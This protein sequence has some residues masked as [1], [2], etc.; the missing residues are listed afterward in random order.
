MSED[1]EG[2]ESEIEIELNRISVSSFEADDSDTEVSDEASVCSETISDDLPE[3]VIS[4]LN[5][6]KS[7]NQ[8]AE[9]LIL[10]DL[11][12]GETT[13]NTY[14]IVSSH[15][16]DC[17]AEL[18]TE[19]NEDPE[20][21]KKR[22]LFEIENEDLQIATTPSYNSQS[23]SDE[24]VTDDCFV[25]ADLDMS[26][27]RPHHEAEEKCRQEF[28]QWEK[29]QKELEDKKRK[30][31]K[32]EREAQE[33]QNEE[34]HTRR[35]Q[36]PEEFE[37]ERVKLELLRK[38]HQT[39]IEDELEKEKKSWRDKMMQREELIMKLQ[40]Q[41]EEERKALEE[42]KAKERQHLAEQQNTAAV[43]IQARFRSFLIHKKYAPILKE[44]KDERKKKILE[45]IER[46][47]K[48]KEEKM[49]RQI[50]ENRQKKEEGKKRQEELERQEYLE[51]MRRHEE[52]E[53]KEESLRLERAKQLQIREEQRELGEKRAET[54]M[55]ESGENNKENIKRD[56]QTENTKIIREQKQELNKQVE[57]QKGKQTEMVDKTNNWIIPAERNLTPTPNILGSE[58]EHSSQVNNENIYMNLL[59]H[60]EEY[61]PQTRDLNKALNSYTSK[62]EFVNFG[63]SDMVKPKANGICS[64]PPN[65]QPS[66]ASNR[67]VK[68]KFSQSETMQKTVF[69]MEDANEEVR[70]TWHRIQDVAECS[71]R[72]IL[73]EDIEKKRINWMNTCKSWFQVYEEN[74][75]KQATM[76]KRPRKSSASKMPPLSTQKIIYSGP[77]STVHQVTTLT[78]EDLPAC[79]LSTLSEC[80][81]LQ[82]LTLRRCGLVA[83]EGL[84][85]CRDLKY[86]N[87]EENNIQMIDCEN[88]E[89]LCILILNKNHLSSVCGLDGCINL[90]NLEL[91]YNRIT[92]IG[93]LES[94]KNLQQLIVDHNQLISTKGLCEAPTLIHLDC[95]F[96]HL[97]QVEG[98]ENCGL[99][100]ILKL[101]SNNLQE[102]P[103]LENHVLLRELYLDDNNISTVRM[104]SFY[105]LPLLQILLL[106]QNRLTELMPLNSFVSLEKLDIKNNCLSDLKGVIAQLSG[107][108]KLRE[109]SVNG[110]PL[111]QE[112]NW[113]P[114][115]CKVLPSLQFLD[116]EILNCHTSPTTERIKGS[117]S[118]TFLGNCQVQIE[119]NVLLK[120]KAAELGIAS[121]IVSAQG[122]CWYFNQ[123]M[124]LSIKHRQAHEYGELNITDRGGPEA[125]QNHLKQTSTGCLQENNL[126]I[127][128]KTEDEQVLLDPSKRWIT[129]GHI[130]AT[131]INSFIPVHQKENKEDQ[132]VKQK[133][134][135]SCIN[136]NEESKDNN[137]MS[138]QLKLE[139]SV[140]VASN[141]ERDQQ[142]ENDTERLHA[143]ASVIQSRWRQ[144]HARRKADCTRTE[145]HQFIETL[146]QKHEAATLIQAFWKGFLLRKKLASALAAVKSD[147]VEDDYEEIN[148]DD[149]TFSEA[150]LEKEWLTVDSTRFPSKT[151]LL[152]NQL[153]WPKNSRPSSSC[154][155]ANT[156]PLLP[157]E[158]WQCVNRPHSY[159]A[160]N[161]HFHSRSGKGTMSQ[162]SDWKEKEKLSLISKKEEKISEEWGFKDISTAQLMLKRAHKMKP[163]KYSNKNLDPAVRLAL[164]KNNENKHLHVKPPRKTQPISAGYFEG[165]KE[166]FS[167]LDPTLY[168]K[169]QKRKD[170]TYQWLHTQFLDYEAASS[171]NT[172]SCHFL[173]ELDPAIRDSRRAQFVASPVSRED[174]DL[175]LVSMASGSALTENREK[176]KQPHRHSARTSKTN[177]STPEKSCLGPSHKERISFRDHPVQLSGGWGA[178]KKRQKL[179][180]IKL[181]ITDNLTVYSEFAAPTAGRAGSFVGS[182][183]ARG[184]GGGVEA[185][186]YRCRGDPHA[187]SRFPFSR[188]AASFAAAGSHAHSHAHRFLREFRLTTADDARKN[189][190]NSRTVTKW[191]SQLDRG[192]VG[193][194]ASAG[195]EREGP[196]P[197]GC[198]DVASSG[199]G[200]TCLSAQVLPC[201]RPCL[202]RRAESTGWGRDA[203]GRTLV[204]QGI[205]AALSE[206]RDKSETVQSQ[207]LKD[208]NKIAL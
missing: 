52:Y 98:I 3:S 41:I 186:G 78:L 170:Y 145:N 17:L 200:A 122:Q 92:R 188:A 13:S 154:E 184:G 113:R 119:E 35:A 116:G 18:A 23:T 115:L 199:P 57:V 207:V 47:M 26:I 178:G 30:K 161:T 163:K 37:D 143:A 85:N 61:Y 75:R 60:V 141:M 174:T 148:V 83:L 43:K 180:N 82:A 38:K 89:K 155:H 99:L 70:D 172:K 185:R 179:T 34:E 86:I 120:R 192:Q 139:Q 81:N 39:A 7:R 11:E 15:A 149:F 50:E 59:T 65:V 25:T 158:D 58:K 103:R 191:V 127:M 187:L 31:W 123:L 16:S 134:T 8:D 193:L 111:L 104:F 153:H 33:K 117:E 110:N 67:E 126:V 151:L 182:V 195:T 1:V 96:N 129:A 132:I 36:C 156:W 77:W 20:Q 10:Q 22:V 159:S 48:E 27:S 12:D 105:W 9:K 55:S 176:N 107:C 164:F 162:L 95:S 24:V 64:S 133:S 128:G 6:I 76:K 196:V 203:P 63:A 152:S 177:I 183:P 73:P 197:E 171:K 90:Q 142:F 131:F 2:I 147:E 112:R 138:A 84:S 87:V 168:E 190:S 94:L 124:K 194:R 150:A 135:E 118:R 29:R 32:A 157:Q 79:S 102:P 91:S 69:L 144:Y 130:Q 71:S 56:K 101:Q 28:E 167:Q 97:T 42:E 206:G 93:G 66:S 121:S 204:C 125:L 51:Q 137:N 62:N 14:G 181:N 140:I 44:W 165:E 202:V 54:T 208:R 169:L 74:K 45:E 19:Y 189:L 4:Y 40:L 21:F 100:Q 108:H 53:K 201:E 166:E 198:P 5:F 205:Q 146:R 175:D 160:E 46:E 49:T 88:L 173:P 80:S 114:S 68:D 72:L 109:L 106:S 136:C